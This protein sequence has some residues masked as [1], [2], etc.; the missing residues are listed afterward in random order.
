M[1]RFYDKNQKPLN[2]VFWK[3]LMARGD[4]YRLLQKPTLDGGCVTTSWI[5]VAAAWE[6]PPAIF[7]TTVQG[8][9]DFTTFST[10][11]NDA[12]VAHD[13]CAGQAREESRSLKKVK[14]ATT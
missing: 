4:V 14:G 12:L 1:L 9:K 3:R 6:E 7:A 2:H 13:E 10:T 11:Q 8:L 5:G